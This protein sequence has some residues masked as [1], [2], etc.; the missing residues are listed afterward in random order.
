MAMVSDWLPPAVV[1][2]T[3]LTV[4]LLKVY[5]FRRGVVGGGGKPVMCRLLGR[6]P[7]WSRGGNNA[8]V[9]L[10]FGIAVLNL[11]QAAHALMGR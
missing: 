1:G 4:A 7:S 9:I 8:L 6:C 5:G 10:F 2:V 3:F 11:I